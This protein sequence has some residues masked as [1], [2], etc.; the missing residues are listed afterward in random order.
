MLRALLHF[1]ETGKLGAG[2]LTGGDF[3]SPFEEAVARVI[4]E[5]GYHVHAQV[6]VSSF[7]IDLGVIDSGRPGQYI[8]G[9]E[10]DGAAYHS[11]RSA[12]D[13]DRL[14]QEVL[15]GLGWRLYRIWSTDWFRNPKRETDKLLAAI[16]EAAESQHAP[17]VDVVGPQGD[18]ISARQPDELVASIANGDASDIVYRNS[19]A[20]V[21][22]YKECALSVP[23]GRALLDLSVSDVA[24]LSQVVVE[25]EGPIHTEEVARRIREAFG[26]QKTGGR[27]LTHVK[28]SLLFLERSGAIAQERE[29]WSVPGRAVGFIRN[30]RRAAL[31]LRKAAMIA[32]AEYQLAIS[33][34]LNEA[35]ALSRDDLIV[36]TARL[37][38]FDRTGPDLTQEIE[39]EVNSLI[40]GRTIV[41]D[42]EKLRVT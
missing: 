25:T 22:D 4:R 21:D 14:R 33:V 10:C 27:I 31:P 40:Q 15:E 12:R 13:R 26:L 6:G 38:G 16:S 39:R 1:A 23:I 7:R 18:P 9:V 32:P 37:F 24:R 11:A 35:V 19:Q 5:A 3:D 41:Y 8:L 29:F 20:Q 36:Q 17:I 34:A 28:N 2:A 30:R 42:G